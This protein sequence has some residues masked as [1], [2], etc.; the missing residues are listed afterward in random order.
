MLNESHILAVKSASRYS[1]FLFWLIECH[2]ANIFIY[3]YLYSIAA[4]CVHLEVDCWAG[5]QVCCAWIGRRLYVIISII[6]GNQAMMGI[7]FRKIF[8]VIETLEQAQ[9]SPLSV[10]PFDAQKW[11]HRTLMSISIMRE[12]GKYEKTRVFVNVYGYGEIYL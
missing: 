2:S 10:P 9:A 12:R 8:A 6:I 3:I 4:S 1:C 7:D 5:W 11:V